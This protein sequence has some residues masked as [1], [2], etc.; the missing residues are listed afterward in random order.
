M[1]NIETS[2]NNLRNFYN[3]D[4]T[5]DYN[6]RIDKLSKLS[7][8]LIKWEQPLLKALYDDLGKSEEEAYISE[9][10]IVKHEV[11]YLI[12]N[13]KKL[14]RK[15]K[16]KTP[17]MHFPSNSYIIAEPL[18][19]VLIM[20]PWN[21][22]LQL[23]LAPLAAAIAAGNTV[24]IKPSRYSSNTSKVIK[25]MINSI[26][27]NTY[28]EVFLGGSQVNQE[29]LQHKFDFIFFTGSVNVGKIVMQKASEFLTPVALELGGKSPVYIDSSANIKTTASRLAWGKF[30]N[31]GQ[32]CVAPDYVLCHEKIYQKLLIA[33][34]EEIN[35]MYGTN[36]IYNQEYGKI[37][38][39]KHFNRLIHLLDCGTLAYGGYIDPTTRKIAPSLVIGVDLESPLMQ[40]EIFGPILPIIKVNNFKEAIS[41]IKNKPKPLAAY[42]FSKNT[43][44]IDYFNTKLS[45]GGGCINDCI[46]HLANSNLPFGGVGESGMGSYHGKKSFETFSHNKSILKKNALID[47]K[48]RKPPL[49]GKLDKLKKLM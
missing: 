49:K 16:V 17:I 21:Y 4:S 19:V 30:L 11:N 41:F 10:A 36:P 15:H 28:I 23:T 44:Q 48:L 8:A 39:E 1:N 14:M 38:N 35:T 18:G 47:I 24:I 43:D 27:K 32:T 22:P 9:L 25:E 6:F 45:F 7:S 29:L 34:K 37:I 13:L 46:I 12:S 40:E 42:L 20:S 3:S 33:L 2:I 31:A 5:I 26:Y